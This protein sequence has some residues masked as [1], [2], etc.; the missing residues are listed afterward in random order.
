M[1]CLWGLPNTEQLPDSSARGLEE[2]SAELQGLASQWRVHQDLYVRTV[3]YKQEVPPCLSTFS[4]VH[5]AP[6]S[7]HQQQSMRFLL[8]S[9]DRI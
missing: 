2:R 8:A 4:L 5:E 3:L 6:G 9:R 1:Q 7:A